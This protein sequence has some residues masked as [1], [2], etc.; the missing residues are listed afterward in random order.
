MNHTYQPSGKISPLFWPAAAAMLV[1]TAAAALLCVYGIQASH[2]A[3]LDMMIYFAVTG[4]IADFGAFLCI[5]GG[6][7]RKPAF[8]KAGGIVLAVWYWLLL[9]GF[10]TPVKAVLTAEQSVWLW[11]WDGAWKEA[12]AQFVHSFMNSAGMGGNGEIGVAGG[13]GALWE[14]FIV[15]PGRLRMFWE[16][17]LSLKDS[18]AAVTGKS[19]NTLFV[20]PGIVCVLLL[21]VLFLAA[22]V[23]FGLAF[24]QQ[25]RAPFCEI[26]GKWAKQTVMNLRCQTEEIFLSRLLLG[27][28]TVLADL[29]PID[30]GNEDSYVKVSVF[31]ADRNGTFYAS[32][33]KMAKAENHWRP[34]YK[35]GSN[36]ETKKPSKRKWLPRGKKPIYEEEQLAEYILLDRGTG[37]F[38]LSRCGGKAAK[39]SNCV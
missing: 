21:A 25:G 33:S 15:W 27:D 5:K 17:V 13:E 32:V 29:E 20:M 18:G 6:R 38:L 12:L 31:A 2:A 16:P 24:W 1:I 39:K 7:V 8:A 3:L 30:G 28:T 37:L 35:S 11:K 19:G 14:G 26:S 34:S 4:R 9:I 10:Y 22:V 23:Q 36:I